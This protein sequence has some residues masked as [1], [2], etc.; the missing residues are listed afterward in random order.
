MAKRTPPHP[1][2][3]AWTTAR[4]WQFIRAGLRA[5]YRRWP[6]R[7]HAL[8]AARRS[9]K[10]GGKQKWE[11]RCAKCNKWYKQT[12]VQVDHVTPAGTLKDYTDLPTFVSKLFCSSEGLQ[13]LC[14]P[15]HKSKTASEKRVVKK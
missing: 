6:P 5:M 13:V 11:Y 8:A 3:P 14:K 9:K 15:C 10:G 1:A 7:Y 2:Y 12:E 4:Y